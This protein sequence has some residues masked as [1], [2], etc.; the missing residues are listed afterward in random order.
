[1]INHPAT[2]EFLVADR[3]RELRAASVRWTFARLARRARCERRT[4]AAP[5][6][7]AAK[8][9]AVR[10]PTPELIPRASSSGSDDRAA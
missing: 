6:V 8:L 4:A 5:A 7:T 3:Q 2:Y 1:M 10:A 9:R